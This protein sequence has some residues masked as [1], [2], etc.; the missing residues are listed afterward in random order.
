VFWS[1]RGHGDCKVVAV[2]NVAASNEILW[3]EGGEKEGR[4]V[5]KTH[6]NRTG[7]KS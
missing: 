6:E 1:E 5:V 2:G 3:R 4:A 7:S